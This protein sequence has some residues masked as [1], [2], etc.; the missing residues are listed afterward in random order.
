LVSAVVLG[1]AFQ[2]PVAFALLVLGLLLSYV[3][4]GAGAFRVWRIARADRPTA[5]ALTAPGLGQSA[6]TDG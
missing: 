6:E 2:V 5:R 4:I 1:I 3:V